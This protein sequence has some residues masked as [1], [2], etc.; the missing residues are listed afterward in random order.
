MINLLLFF[1][2]L[3][4]VEFFSL[5]VDTTEGKT[6]SLSALKGRKTLIV[7]AD[8]SSIY[9]NQLEVISKLQDQFANNLVV[10]V[11]VPEG[12]TKRHDH[13]SMGTVFS[14]RYRKANV[15]FVK[16]DFS[17]IDKKN[18]LLQWLS[19]KNLNGRM[20]VKIRT[21]FQKLLIDSKGQLS[22]VFSGVLSFD[23]EII[24]KA[25]EKAD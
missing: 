16:T 25:I 18:E 4:S 24:I 11:L 1:A 19:D 22:G 6:L 10:L 14:D 12:T 23:D 5:H 2:S 21:D 7:N 9:Q 15:Y 3:L 17:V 8:P 13:V 20:S